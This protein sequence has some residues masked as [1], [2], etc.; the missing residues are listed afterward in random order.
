MDTGWFPCKQNNYCNEAQSTNQH[1]NVHCARNGICL[2]PATA[3]QKTNR[4]MLALNLPN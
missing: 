3:V 2:I 4:L 1:P